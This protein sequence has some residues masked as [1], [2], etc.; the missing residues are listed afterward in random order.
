MRSV[1]AITASAGLLGCAVVLA[2]THHGLTAREPEVLAEQALLLEAE[3][4]RAA[5]WL[6]GSF[7]RCYA[8]ADTLSLTEGSPREQRVLRVHIS[9][10]CSP[11]GLGP[12][13]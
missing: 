3:L 11:D 9:Q 8:M 2:T 4:G 1:D 10:A 6:G 5:L 12:F 13:E 7:E